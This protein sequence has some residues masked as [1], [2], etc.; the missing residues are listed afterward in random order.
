MKNA[1]KKKKRKMYACRGR[2]GCLLIQH[3][4]M[5]ANNYIYGKAA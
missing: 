4:E 2:K 5:I 1:K 3:E